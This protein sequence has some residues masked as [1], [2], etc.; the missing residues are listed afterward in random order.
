MRVGVR[1]RK[2]EWHRALGINLGLGLE[3]GV[4][5][6]RIGFRTK[7]FGCVGAMGRHDFGLYIAKITRTTCLGPMSTRSYIYTT[8]RLLRVHISSGST[9]IPM[10]VLIASDLVTRRGSHGSVFIILSRFS[11]FFRSGVG[12]SGPKPMQSAETT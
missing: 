11:R 3:F 7:G 2:F 6:D 12:L 5:C 1:L 4:V 9:G 8:C 10:P